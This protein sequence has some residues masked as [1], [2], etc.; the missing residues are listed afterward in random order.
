MPARPDLAAEAL[1]GKVK[2]ERYVQARPRRVITPA[3]ALRKTPEAG[4]ALETE[5]VFGEIFDVYEFRGGWAWGQARRDGYVGYM[6][7]RAL[8]SARPKPT[9]RVRALRGF[10]YLGPGIKATPLGYLPFGAEVAVESTEG[11]FS[12]LADGYVFSGHLAPL[13]AIE[14]DPVSVAETFLGIPYL[15]GGKSSLGLDCSGLVQTACHA[16]GIAAPRDSDM[17]EKI[18]GEHI[19]LP[20]DPAHYRR[21]DLLFW[22]GH[23]ALARGD[24][25]MIH[26]T[27]FSM[28]VII[29][30]L[31]EALARI[32]AQGT[33]LR[34]AR[35]LTFG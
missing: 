13:D 15:W 28:N 24:G 19:E 26:A 10:L 22:P 20:N 17:Q 11:D 27:A 30:P 23:V 35:R 18:L 31:A 32:E 21:G 2:A 4:R 8:S 5:L 7:E 33:P 25:T 9:H 12:R 14:A 34:T 1:H 16:C 3:A 6:E 29:E